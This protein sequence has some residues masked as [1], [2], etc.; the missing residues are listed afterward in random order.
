[1]EKKSLQID[2][3]YRCG[4]DLR[5]IANDQP[6]PECGLLAERSRRVTDEL[7]NTRPR[8]LRKLSIG[9]CV[10]LAGIVLALLWQPLSVTLDDRFLWTVVTQQ[11]GTIWV[12]PRPII[13]YFQLRPLGFEIAAALLLVGI[14]LLTSPERYG[15]ADSTDR[16]RR[17]W[18]RAIAAVPLAVL[19]LNRYVLAHQTLW[20]GLGLP[21]PRSF[22]L[23]TLVLTAVPL[24]LLLFYQLRNLARRAR[25]ANLATNCALIGIGTAIALLYTAAVVVISEKSKQGYF[26]TYWWERSNVALA[27]LGLTIMAAAVFPC[28]AIWLLLRFAISFHRASRQL[29]KK[30]TRD[31]RATDIS[32]SP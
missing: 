18:L 13:A 19:L 27:L 17:I 9:T 14:L 4:Y 28:W 7:H 5:G 21:D 31:D 32:A 25:N 20:W 24:P 11:S 10:M 16:R 1:M 6:C 15:P 8:W 29:R 23:L 12:T 26:G 30:W 3:C 2:E 22:F